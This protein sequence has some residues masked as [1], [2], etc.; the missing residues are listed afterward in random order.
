M[1]AK[2]YLMQYRASMERTNELAE[3]L[4]ELRNRLCGLVGGINNDIG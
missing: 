1:T 4:T 2:A 3:H